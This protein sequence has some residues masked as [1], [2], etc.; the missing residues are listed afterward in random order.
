MQEGAMFPSSP[1]LKQYQ[2]RGFLVIIL[3][4]GVSEEFFLAE[5]LGIA[6]CFLLGLADNWSELK[7]ATRKAIWAC[8][9]DICFSSFCE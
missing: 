5:P 6:F 9:F 1:H 7:D 4:S 3:G 8:S 2:G